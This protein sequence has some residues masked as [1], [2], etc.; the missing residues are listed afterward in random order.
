VDTVHEE[1]QKLIQR[2]R[3]QNP[4]ILFTLQEDQSFG[5]S[6]DD[7]GDRYMDLVDVLPGEQ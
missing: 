3:S 7:R 4:R 5:W 1:F 2:K 6:P